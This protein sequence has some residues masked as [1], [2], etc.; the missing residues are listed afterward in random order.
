VRGLAACESASFKSQRFS[1]FFLERAQLMKV[2]RSSKG[3]TLIELLVVIAIIGLLI[4]LLLPAVQKAREAA[5]RNTCA[6]NLKQIGLAL[7]VFQDGRKA[8]PS[9]GEG[10]NYQSN[11]ALAPQYVSGTYPRGVG[12]APSVGWG[13][14]PA[15]I[16][17]AP[18]GEATATASSNE[19]A[20][21]IGNPGGY[22]VFYYILPYIE[23]QE[24]YDSIDN[25]YYYNDTA[26]QSLDLN[27]RFPGQQA[28]PTYLCPTNPLRPKSGLDSFGYGYTDYGATVYTDM[29]PFWAGTTAPALRNKATRMNGGLHSGGSTIGEIIDGLSKTI[30]IAEDVGRNET[31]PGAYLDPNGGVNLPFAQRGFW[32]WIE[33][34]TGFGVSGPGNQALGGGVGSGRVINNNSYPFGGPANCNWNAQ[35]GNCG[36]NDEIF[37]FHGANANVVFMDGH[38]SS[39]S[40]DI[41]PVVLRYLVTS[42][43]KVTPGTT[44]Y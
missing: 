4:A 26:N 18:T 41:N 44:D 14:N 15:T 38:V 25:R 11:T 35:A 16:F 37:S 23:Q 31:M 13:Y 34:D 9:T 20:A 32:R 28:V 30:A 19:A 22:S 1:F 3:F 36:P 42:A 29:D 7:H 8:F 21:S 33:P 40:Q 43:E 6:N 27:G 2:T 17:D 12:P 24:V 39:L 10:T 5:N